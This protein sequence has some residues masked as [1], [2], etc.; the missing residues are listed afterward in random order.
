MSSFK[1]RCARL[2]LRSFGWRIEGER[3]QPESYVLIA[4]PH[5]SNWDFPL[6]LLFAAAFDIRIKFLAKHSLFQPPLGWLMRA[7]GGL[8]IVRHRNSNVVEDMAATFDGLGALVIAVPAEGTRTR[9]DYWKSGFYHI[10]R[11]AKVPIVPS[12][13]D[14]GQKRGGFGPA[15]VP[16]GDISADMQ[17][18]RDFYAPM[19][20]KFADQFGPVKLREEEA[21]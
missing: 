8:P 17:Y 6:M 15:L 3:P 13:L 9:T 4:A 19:Q 16:S 1:S 18:F 20:G 2:V 7:F 21:D 12:Y 5:T 14:F 10:A 11:E